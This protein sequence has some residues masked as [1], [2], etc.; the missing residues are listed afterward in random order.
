MSEERQQVSVRAKSVLKLD[1]GQSDL[2]Y[3]Y[4]KGASIDGMAK[5]ILRAVIFNKGLTEAKVFFKDFI[6]TYKFGYRD[7]DDKAPTK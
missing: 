1:T 7:P 3:T 2:D 4:E 5:D 6:H